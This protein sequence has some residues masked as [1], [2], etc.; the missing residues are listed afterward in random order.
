MGSKNTITPSNDLHKVL[1]YMGLEP[2]ILKA[3]GNGSLSHYA[4]RAVK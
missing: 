1:F 4:I 2:T 3:V